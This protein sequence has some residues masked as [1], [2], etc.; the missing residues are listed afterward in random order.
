[1][2]VIV[3]ICAVVLLCSPLYSQFNL[4]K[5]LTRMKSKVDK[6]LT[7]VKNNVDKGLTKGKN[8]IDKTLTKAK[9]DTDRELTNT[10]KKVD[11]KLTKAKNIT[12][13]ELTT[14]KENVD[15]ELTTMKNDV[16]R[17]LTD[18][19]YD[20]DHTLTIAREDIETEW[21]YFWATACGVSSNIKKIQ[22][23]FDQGEIDAETRDSLLSQY[24]APRDCGMGVI[25]DSDGGIVLTDGNGTPSDKPVAE[26]YDDLPDILDWNRKIEMEDWE[27]SLSEKFVAGWLISPDLLGGEITW[28]TEKPGAVTKSN[29]LR[30]TTGGH[31]MTGARR[32]IK[33]KD[34][35]GK[36]LKDKNGNQLYRYRL[37]KGT[38]FATEEGEAIHASFDGKVSFIEKAYKGFHK[39]IVTSQTTGHVQE[40]LYM[41]KSDLTSSLV[42][43]TVSKG[44]I[45]GYADNIQRHPDYTN[46]PNHVHVSYISPEGI[47]IAPN[48]KFAVTSDA[49]WIA[50]YCKP[51]ICLSPNSE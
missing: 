34:K 42:N 27:K 15:R 19:K 43:R 45:I 12:D 20:V 5:E 7:K 17:E 28:M 38:D 29:K 39:V 8:N 3:S 13:S 6:K 26:E 50:K 47:Y 23:K 18:Y 1:M 30:E 14:A 16:D 40:T 33:L 36:L 2:K 4:G 46:I 32:A 21:N 25:A 11:K 22:R 35:N 9:K 10:K 48:N 41:K 49:N 37:H 44:D 51:G 31:P 24:P